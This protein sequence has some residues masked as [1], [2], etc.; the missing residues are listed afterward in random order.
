VSNDIEFVQ[1]G[2]YVT[3]SGSDAETALNL[4][5]A[6]RKQTILPLDGGGGNHADINWLLARGYQLL[7]KVTHWQQVEKLA[8]TVLNWQTGPW[9]RSFAKLPAR[10]REQRG[11]L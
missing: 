5:A 3:M 1:T 8:A 6:C 2:Q 7:V 10:A 9:V 11:R 4:N